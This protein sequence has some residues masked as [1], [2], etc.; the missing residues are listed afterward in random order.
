MMTNKS[1]QFW[2]YTRL[3]L[4]QGPADSKGTIPARMVGLKVGL[5]RRLSD[6]TESVHAG[7]PEWQ[8]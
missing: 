3:T 4:Q 7:T 8:I 2:M 5:F 1:G 6:M